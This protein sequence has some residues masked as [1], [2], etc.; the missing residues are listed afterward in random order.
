ML[1]KHALAELEE[2]P[3]IT[4]AVSSTESRIQENGKTKQ[5]F[6]TPVT[7]KVMSWDGN[8]IMHGKSHEVIR[9][10]FSILHTQIRTER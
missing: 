2:L 7:A 3:R 6:S 1:T 10:V 8:L 9:V 4:A 5:H